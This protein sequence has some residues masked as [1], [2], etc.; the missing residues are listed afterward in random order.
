MMKSK[1][2]QAPFATKIALIFFIALVG[3]FC[4][5]ISIVACSQF[6][7][8]ILVMKW[9]QILQTVCT[10]VLPAFFLAYILD[11][12]VTYLK[13]TSIRSFPIWVIVLLLMPIALPAVNLFKA[14]N[15]LVVL[16]D[17]MNG[18]A[19]WM[20]QME[21]QSQIVTEQFLS[22]STISGLVF[23]LLVMAIVPAVGEELFFRGILQT[24]LGEKMNRHYAVWITAFI[25]SAIH[26]QFYG[27]VPRLLLGAV[28]GYLFLF[29]GSIWASIAAH[30]IN[31]MLAVILFFLTF[32]G[33]WKFDIDALGT[34]ETWWLGIVSVGFLFLLFGQLKRLK[35]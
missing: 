7:D 14:L 33:Y 27:F 2:S 16:P 9:L 31:N 13:F 4:S 22:V 1:F 20:Q 32:N 35:E 11:S 17:F 8:N 3:L 26:L 15:D 24:V 28:L 5:S 10:F 12:G 21:N 30:F 25:F 6:M 18:L 34:N 19:A 29:T 23:N